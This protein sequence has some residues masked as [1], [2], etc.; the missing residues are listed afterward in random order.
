MIGVCV[1]CGRENK[2]PKSRYCSLNCQQ[3]HWHREHPEKRRE[4]CRKR[5]LKIAGGFIAHKELLGCSACGY[6]KCGAALDYHHTRDKLFPIN[7]DEWA[8]TRERKRDLKGEI[9]KCV[10]L[11]KNCHTE[12]HFKE[13][14]RW[15]SNGKT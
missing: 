4:S 1:F 2:R 11:C 3:T 15:N 12:L 5:R 13:G 6:S 9:A 7:A 14:G 10:L 8:G